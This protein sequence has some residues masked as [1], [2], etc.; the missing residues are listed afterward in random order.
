RVVTSPSAISLLLPVLALGLRGVPM[1]GRVRMDVL[2]R[3]VF[4]LRLRGMPGIRIGDRI[5]LARSAR[6]RHAVRTMPLPFVHLIH[7]QP[8]LCR[9]PLTL[10]GGPKA[11]EG[12]AQ[13]RTRR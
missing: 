11:P 8:P 9:L 4:A 7:V 13:A 3:G 1:E 12:L 5:G 2:S 10:G 6:P